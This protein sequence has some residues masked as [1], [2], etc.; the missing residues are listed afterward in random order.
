[1]HDEWT[2]GIIRLGI[3]WIVML[4]I[5]GSVFPIWLSLGAPRDPKGVLCNDASV[6][7]SIGV[8]MRGRHEVGCASHDSPIIEVEGLGK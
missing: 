3:G 2:Q 6:M 7:K 8:M 1:M 5:I 4:L